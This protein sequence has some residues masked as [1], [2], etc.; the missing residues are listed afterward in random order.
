MNSIAPKDLQDLIQANILSEEKVLEIEAY[1]H[2]RKK[3]S[4]SKLNIIFGV[5]GALLVSLGLI[6]FIAHN[7]D[8]LSVI[9]KTICAFLPLAVGQLLCVYALLYKKENRLWLEA[10]AIVLFFAVAASISLI[11]QVYHIDGTLGS[12]LF[13]WILL[14]AAIVYLM[15]SAI[16]ALLL[17]AISAWY[18]IEISYG[19]NA[20]EI[21]WL[22]LAVFIFLTPHYLNFL[23]HKK[24]SNIFYWYNWFIAGSSLICLGCFTGD[25]FKSPLLL[26]GS[27]LALVTL[28]YQTGKFLSSAG[29]NFFS[30]P[31]LKLGIAGVIV[32]FLL[33]SFEEFW[34][35]FD[36]N[37]L[38]FASPLI[39]I[40]AILFVVCSY[41]FIKENIKHK[42]RSIDPVE[43]SLYIFCIVAFANSVIGA[44]VINAWLLVIALWYIK[45]GSVQSD[46]GLLNFG[47]FI[48]ASMAVARFFD[49]KIP[50]V[51]R[52][53]FF[54]A[55]GIGF[56]AANYRLMKKRRDIV[57]KKKS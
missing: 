12:F 37:T 31:F 33:L 16:T 48:I 30:N 13:T 21:A 54:L 34:D 39:Y 8:E 17:I 9:L 43:T 29:K 3:D 40:A 10:S 52:G 24:T 44:F 4:P 42:W 28:F 32:I 57:Q 36:R 45:K 14:T 25:H 22:Y 38:S 5:L 1:L 41:N 11:S 47:L 6:L 23:K 26:F 46:F 7:W 2:N 50:F 19:Y 20:N 35:E 27:Y 53:I 56:F 15:R 55:A 51:W 18:A 49:D